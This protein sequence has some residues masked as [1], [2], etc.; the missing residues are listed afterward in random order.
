LFLNEKA[1]FE[2][3][4]IM[5]MRQRYLAGSMCEWHVRSNTPAR[6]N[7]RIFCAFK[8]LVLRGDTS[9]LEQPALL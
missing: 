5:K 4:G 1:I 8:C 6:Q 7:V 3:T 2:E 9:G